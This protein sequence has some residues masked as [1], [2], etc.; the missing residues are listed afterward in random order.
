MLL[1]VGLNLGMV[2]KVF[3]NSQQRSPSGG[4]C[5]RP[6]YGAKLVSLNEVDPTCEISH[7]LQVN[8]IPLY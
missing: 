1:F 3:A 4:A 2:G 8:L 5:G 6:F 7:N